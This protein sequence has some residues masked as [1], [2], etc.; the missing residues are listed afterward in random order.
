MG[1]HLFDFLARFKNTV[2]PQPRT[3]APGDYTFFERKD[4]TSEQPDKGSDDE[5]EDANSEIDNDECD[6][7]HE[8]DISKGEQDCICGRRVWRP[9]PEIEDEKCGDD[10]LTSEK[11]RRKTVEKH[12]F[13]AWHLLN[14]I[15]EKLRKSDDKNH[16]LEEKLRIRHL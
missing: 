14:S 4:T 2:S 13:H 11:H 10:E 12:M 8:D 15:E 6:D 9:N 1:R 7:E 3:P 16:K 5:Y